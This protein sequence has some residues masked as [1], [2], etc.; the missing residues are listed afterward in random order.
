[1]GVENELLEKEL[2][3]VSQDLEQQKNLS[4][5]LEDENKQL[6]DQVLD[7]NKS[8]NE[9]IK[10]ND[11]FAK[12]ISEFASVLKNEYDLY[13]ENTAEGIYILPREKS[14]PEKI[15]TPKEEEKVY[16]EKISTQEK[17]YPGKSLSRKKSTQGKVVPRK[18]TN[19]AKVQPEEISDDGIW[20]FTNMYSLR[21]LHADMIEIST[22]LQEIFCTIV[23]QLLTYY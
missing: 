18:K 7:Q 9:Q 17:S 2:S 1:M 11:Q 15:S 23:L 21:N 5:H 16:P 13:V 19:P 12:N 20:I 4:I 14:N 10:L 6:K 8:L 3:K 22:P